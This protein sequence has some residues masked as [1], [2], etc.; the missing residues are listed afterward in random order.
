MQIVEHHPREWCWYGPSERVGGQV[1]VPVI[2]SDGPRFLPL[3]MRSKKKFLYNSIN[4][5]NFLYNFFYIKNFYLSLWLADPRL[6]GGTPCI[7][8]RSVPGRWAT[9]WLRLVPE[10]TRRSSARVSL[11][12]HAN[13]MARS[14]RT[15]CFY[16]RGDN[17]QTG[18]QELQT[19]MQ[20]RK[21]ERNLM[22]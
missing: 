9:V 17:W 6:C 8:G 3:G 14:C 12:R 21:K 19:H 2:S 18:E 22:E 13:I 20:E 10:C 4:Q 1:E 15:S 11:A 16:K 7:P 5:K